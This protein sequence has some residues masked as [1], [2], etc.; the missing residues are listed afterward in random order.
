MSVGRLAIVILAFSVAAG[1]FW[2]GSQ[3]RADSEV[4]PITLTEDEP[5]AVRRDDEAS[6][7]EPVRDDEDPTSDPPTRARR[8]DASRDAADAEAPATDDGDD[9]A[10]D[11][12][13]DAA[14]DD[15]A[16]VN[17]APANSAPAGP[18]AA[19]DTNDQASDGDGSDSASDN[20]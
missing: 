19:D 15:G 3:D 10:T 20:T 7:V 17:R 1:G 11:D 2:L 6:G 4:A 14:T 8:A 5:D 12:G 13:D 9:A 18:V 16:R